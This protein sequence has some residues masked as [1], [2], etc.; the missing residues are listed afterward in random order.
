MFTLDDNGQVYINGHKIID[1]NG[2]GG[3]SFDLNVDP[4]FF[5]VGQNLIAVHG[6]DVLTPFHTIGVNLNIVV[7]EPE[8]VD[9]IG[10]VIGLTILLQ[11]RPKKPA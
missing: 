6:A 8:C 4:S 3:S 2:S 7:P 11:R 10:G 1:N 9:V 5:H